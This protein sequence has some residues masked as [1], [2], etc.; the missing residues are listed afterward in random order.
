MVSPHFKAGTHPGGRDSGGS[1]PGLFPT[2]SSRLL[3]KAESRMT[4]GGI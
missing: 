1:V 4:G 2:P 3:A